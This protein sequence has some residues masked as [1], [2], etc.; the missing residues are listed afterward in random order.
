MAPKILHV[1][2]TA[3]WVATYRAE[4]TLRP[5]ALFHDPLA[6]RLAGTL[7]EQITRT[8][9][10]S[11]YVRWSVVIRT[12]IIDNFVREQ[13]AQGVDL[14]LNLG[15]G[16]DTRPYRLELPKKLRW[17]EADFPHVIA[18]KEKVLAS[19]QPRVQLERRSLDL[20]NDAS[21][22]SLLDDLQASAQRILVITEG[23]LPYLSNEQV[24]VLAADLAKRNHFQFWVADYHSAHVMKYLRS[25]KRRK[26]FANA[27]F[28]FDPG[29]WFAFFRSRG[30]REREVKYLAL[31]SQR[32]GRKI[33]MPLFVR[34]LHLV[35]PA[36]VFAESAKYSAYV[37]LEREP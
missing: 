8:V 28:L 17:V 4:E 2:D 20:S 6:S 5:D 21:R 36:R 18:E 34:A 33:P 24:S 35:M 30:W 32:L 1:S 29:D 16:L 14:V 15:A 37:L 25:G 7:G 19:E 13:V 22:A 3:H 9:S 12:A 27:P 10:Y 26:Q 11:K 23:V 31:E